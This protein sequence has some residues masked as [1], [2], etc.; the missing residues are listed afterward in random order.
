MGRLHPVKLHV[1]SL[2][3]MSSIAMASTRQALVIHLSAS[4]NSCG[5][6]R[7]VADTPQFD[8]SLRSGK[9]QCSATPW[10]NGDL[11][12][13]YATMSS[14]DFQGPS[15]CKRRCRRKPTS[16]PPADLKRSAHSRQNRMRV[17]LRQRSAG[18][19]YTPKGPHCKI[20]HSL[21]FYSTLS[22]S[23]HGTECRDG[24]N[25]AGM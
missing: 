19:I 9:G 17:W 23:C 8:T 11:A 1:F 18:P 2:S 14:P 25:A 10:S 4:W 15:A 22:R 20:M 5:Q 6:S 3:D 7:R 12:F 13:A 16:R 24:Y 21:Q